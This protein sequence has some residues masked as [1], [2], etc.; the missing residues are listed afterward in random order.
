MKA[1]NKKASNSPHHQTAHSDMDE[2][3]EDEPYSTLQVILN[4]Q[5]SSESDIEQV[6]NHLISGKIEID[7]VNSEYGEHIK[8]T[9]RN[10][11]NYHSYILHRSPPTSGVAITACSS[12][13]QCDLENI[14]QQSSS[15]HVNKNNNNSEQ[16]EIHSVHLIKPKNQSLGLSV[17][18]Y[19]YKNPYNE[20]KYDRGIFVK[21]IIP[22]SISDRCR[23]IQVNDQIIELNETSLVGLDNVQAISLLKKA[24]ANITL[25]LRR[26]LHG[27]LYE[28]LKKTGSFVMNTSSQEN[29]CL[30]SPENSESDINSDFPQS[31]QENKFKSYAINGYETSDSSTSSK[32][33]R[34]ERPFSVSGLN[35]SDTLYME[36]TDDLID[37]PS[38]CFN[39]NES[40]QKAALIISSEEDEEKQRE[41]LCKLPSASSLRSSSS[42]SSS[43]SSSSPSS[44]VLSYNNTTTS[45]EKYTT[46]RT[47]KASIPNKT[48]RANNLTSFKTKV[49]TEVKTTTTE[50]AVNYISTGY[51]GDINDKNIQNLLGG[52]EGEEF[53]KASYTV[54]DGINNNNNLTSGINSYTSTD[55]SSEIQKLDMKIPKEEYLCE[56]LKISVNVDHNDTEMIDNPSG[57]ENTE[58]SDVSLSGESK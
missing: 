35:Q 3:Q 5:N 1:N 18:G 49:E 21:S 23:S 28:E 17:V 42:L 36:L 31:V 13:N 22:N 37:S 48:I 29:P 4:S 43:S 47:C 38:T 16:T 39:D 45:L 50:Q 46:K 27:F 6:N 57:I 34:E 56:N 33:H 30:K 25:K 20:N 51:Y 12:V 44:S 14:I 9:R 40:V 8:S 2:L 55:F 19:I 52:K 11:S 10:S 54:E 26:Y 53:S 15:S 41:E 32:Q 58:L 7:T 24:N